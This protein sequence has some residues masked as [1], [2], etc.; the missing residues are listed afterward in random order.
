[1][2][3]TLAHVT[4]RCVSGGGA[5]AVAQLVLAKNQVGANSLHRKSRAGPQ[6]CE[7]GGD[8]GQS[9]VHR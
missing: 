1:M 8:A 5:W 6:Q 4:V 2:V 7:T 9:R 3:A